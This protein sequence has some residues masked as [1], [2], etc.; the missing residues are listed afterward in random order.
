[1][2]IT[3]ASFSD[4]RPGSRSAKA[5]SKAVRW[6][7]SP[8]LLAVS[9]ALLLTAFF[10]VSEL[11]T[12]RGAKAHDA[13]AYLTR[14]LG[15]PLSSAS[16]VRTPARIHPALGGKLEMRHGGLKVS[17]GR[18]MLS[19]R[20]AGDAAWRQ[21][22]NGVSRKTAFGRETIAFGVNRVE[23]SLLVDRRQGSNVWRWELGSDLHARI[24][25]DGSVRFAD[26]PLSILP[27]AVLDRD[28]HDITPA[29]LHW[30]LGR[31]TLELRLDDAHL[32]TPY[33]IDPVALV[34]AC[35]PGIGDFAGCS[36]HNISNKS[37]FTGSPIL[38][39]GSV[40]T[41]DL[42]IAQ[43]TV[44]NNDALTAPAGWT[45]IGNLR[46]QGT[47]IE[48]ALYSR[49]ATAA[50]IA[51]TTYSWSWTNKADAAGAI[52][53][54]SGVD[55]TSPFDVTPTDNSGNTASASATGVTTTQNGDMVIAL[56][57]AEGNVTL[58]QDASQT[59][60]QEYTQLSTSGPASR[61]RQTGADA[62]Q[63]SP[64][65]TGA[66][67]ATV[68]AAANWIAHLVTL[69]PALAA[70]G[71][72][73]MTSSISNVSA[74]QTGRTITFT[75]TA[76][77]GGMKN[78]SVTLVVP[79]GWS[80]PSTTA[81]NAGYSTSSA[82]T[83][84]VSAQTITVSSLTVAGGATFTI[85]YGSTAGGGPGATA[86]AT[87][88]AQTWQVQEKSRSTGTLTN[89][90]SSPSI[91]VY[92]GDGSGTL[93]SGTGA[94]SAGQ[95]KTMTFTYTAATGGMS[96]GSVTLV[97]PSGWTAPSTTPSNGGYTT[98]STGT[99]SVSSQT[100]TVSSV[101][102]AAGGTLTI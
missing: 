67:T 43:I 52:L 76:A 19:L 60:V 88:G 53:A 64:G 54:Y 97:V 29:G 75:Y 89:L 33:V 55:A 86:T 101:T 92:A 79:A 94:V 23:Q 62:T 26:S 77:T 90:S 40:S 84:T 81:A 48:Q 73:T 61:A 7:R 66:K 91:T 58:T 1:M 4:L 80:S 59:V 74:S 47:G 95:T 5:G 31:H 34:G 3:M 87:T 37:D 39:P 93:T 2:E 96:N 17:S 27:V 28:G 78:G 41:G 10:A 102:L 8:T 6:F 14:E 82:G 72:G 50:D 44:R 63:A 24:A 49:F 22:A 16:L 25:G 85:T 38:R 18:D 51:T 65:A 32:P 36:V 21:Y 13:S 69:M 9:A 46:T 12:L 99:V 20:F 45:Q 30:S 71:S 42:M 15:S 100:I 68:G 83:L 98:A 57:G 11:A 56:Y 35:G 70:D